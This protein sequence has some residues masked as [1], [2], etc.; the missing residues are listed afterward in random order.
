MKVI[1]ILA[2]VIFSVIISSCGNNDKMKPADAIFT[3][4]IVGAENQKLFIRKETVNQ[5]NLD[6]IDVKADGTFTYSSFLENP[7]YFTFFVGRNQVLLYL[8]PGDSLNFDATAEI[9]SDGKFSGSSVVYNDYLARYTKSQMQ[10][11][12]I[13]EGIFT[14]S[15]TVAVRSIDSLRNSQN[16][17]LSELEKNMEKVD[18]GFVA[19][20]KSRIQYFW[21][22]SH[23]MYPLYFA[24]Y[25]KVDNFKPSAQYE[26]FLGE[27]NLNDSSLVIL[28]EYRQ[29][30]SN[31]VNAKVDR[32][33]KDS[34]ISA[35][36]P[37]FV[38]YQLKKVD[39]LF[40]DKMVKSYASYRVMKDNVLYDGVKDYDIVWPVFEKVCTDIDLIK[41][42]EKQLAE[43]E[44]LK[45][46]N[47]AKDFAGVN[48]K[49]DSIHLSDFK[50]KYV[51]VDVWA[52]WC[53]PC[54]GEIPSLMQI[55]ERM[56][57][58]NIVFISASVDR[59]KMAWQKMLKERKLAGQQIYVGQSD[60]LSGFYKISGIPRFMLF[61][62]EGK[63]LEVS[64][65][66]PTSG[67][68]K[69]LLK[70]AGI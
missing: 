63:I 67:V 69:K 34:T 51:Y 70:L 50:G 56:K 58:N 11:S 41:D 28:P 15:E 57:K 61:D 30:I 3:G 46:G 40:T 64:A 55:E 26:N 18:K 68:D 29:F 14:Q 17:L 10:F 45:T 19:M 22:L 32:Y 25:N 59:D 7:S 8:K 16:N 44:H 33:Y 62:K 49:G 65:D 48:L 66:R 24:Y 42:V 6:T 1:N 2:I 47:P 31:L 5:I 9:V 4:K 54:L 60:L 52:T 20:E 23:I 43:W 37:S 27:L 12:D 39:E 13:M 36:Y 35:Q 38:T 53:N 21:G